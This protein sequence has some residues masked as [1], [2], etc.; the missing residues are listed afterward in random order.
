[1]ARILYPKKAPAEIFVYAVWN[2]LVYLLIKLVNTTS[3]PFHCLSHWEGEK[4]GGNVNLNSFLYL[5]VMMLWYTVNKAPSHNI[6]LII[7]YLL[8]LLYF[9]QV[10]CSNVDYN[11]CQYY[12]QFGL[13]YKWRTLKSESKNV[14]ENCG[15]VIVPFKISCTLLL[16]LKIL[17]KQVNFV[18]SHIVR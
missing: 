18:C 11:C 12:R 7:Y 5:Q 15:L 2:L 6:C 14:A 1:M 8:L 9:Q 3:G 13:C 10:W 4:L 16:L 17:F